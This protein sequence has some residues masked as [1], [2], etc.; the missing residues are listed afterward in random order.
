MLRKLLVIPAL[1]AF[2]LSGCVTTQE[3]QVI[4]EIQQDVQAI[5]AVVPTAESIIAI[6]GLAIPD[7]TEIT[8]IATEICSAV[9]K[10][11]GVRGA[12]HHAPVMVRGVQVKFL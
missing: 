12:L 10:T 4:T 8:Q 11:G 3:Q 1:A 9:G 7:L 6:I 2:T 5:C